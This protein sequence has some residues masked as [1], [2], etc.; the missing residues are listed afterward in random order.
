MTI[1]QKGSALGAVAVLGLAVA[2]DPAG[3]E[4]IFLSRQYTR[5]TTCHFSPTG[6]G[7]LTPYGR[8][9]SG[10]EISTTASGDQSAQQQ[11]PGKEESFLWGALGHRLGNVSFGLDLRPAY[12]GFDVGGR[13]SSM[14]MLMTADLI[15]A[16]RAAGWTVYGELGRQPLTPAKVDSYEYWVGRE[17]EKGYGFR[18][19]RFLPAYGVR[20]ADHTALTRIDL[21]FDAYD[22]VYGVELSRSTEHRLLQLSLGPGRA[23]SILHDDGRRAFTATGRYQMDLGPRTALVVS[24]LFRDTA[25]LAPQ[26]GAAG[27]AF[28]IA[29]TPHVSV[30]SEADAQFEKGAA[31]SPGYVL[32]NETGVEVYR[33]VWLKVSPQLRTLPGDTSSGVFRMLFEANLLPRTHWNVDVSYYRDE[34][35]ASHLVSK[36]FLAQLHLYL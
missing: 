11:G 27:V 24:G 1:R 10:H 20:L 2:A 15:A 21:G 33:G 12:L 29:P 14:E 6:G 19:G 34:N 5:C 30:W 8:S 28:G 26:N 36:T 18:V 16:W 31:G 9:L 35:R 17:T 4:P 7:L 13:T 32:L 23:E 3:A 22:Q 25:R